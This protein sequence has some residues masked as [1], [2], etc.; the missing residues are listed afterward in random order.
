MTAT[1]F[2]CY[3]TQTWNLWIT[4]CLVAAEPI[5]LVTEVWGGKLSKPCFSRKFA[6][7]L[8]LLHNWPKTRSL[9]DTLANKNSLPFNVPG[10]FVQ[11]FEVQL[12]CKSK[13]VT[14]WI[15]LRWFTALNVLHKTV[16]PTFM[17]LGIYIW[18]MQTKRN[19]SLV[20]MLCFSEELYPNYHLCFFLGLFTWRWGTPGKWNWNKGPWLRQ[21]SLLALDQQPLG[22]AKTFLSRFVAQI[23]EFKSK[24]PF[25]RTK[26]KVCHE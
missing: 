4:T 26:P 5:L 8:K 2:S 6:H 12:S 7:N 25:S 9:K 11:F 1:L 24:F 22:F 10:F 14:K 16:K 17:F 20:S 23:K 3:T 21:P 18:T 13:L 15:K 19:M